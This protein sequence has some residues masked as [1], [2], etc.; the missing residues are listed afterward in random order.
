MKRPMEIMGSKARNVIE[1][2]MKAFPDYEIEHVI[3]DLDVR[4]TKIQGSL[5]IKIK[6][7]KEEEKL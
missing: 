4:P 3:A 1:N 2:F 6:K 5:E 7:R